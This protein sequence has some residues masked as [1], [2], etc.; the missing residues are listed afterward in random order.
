MTILPTGGKRGEVKGRTG[1]G[2]RAV[3]GIRRHTGI[4][5]NLVRSAISDG[6][7]KTPKKEKRS[8]WYGRQNKKGSGRVY[9]WGTGTTHRRTKLPPSSMK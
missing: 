4:N 6:G 8:G 5:N 3:R 7:E 1:Q 2:W 9:P